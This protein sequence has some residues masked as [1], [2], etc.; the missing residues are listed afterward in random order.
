MDRG[1][2]CFLFPQTTLDEGLM[3]ISIEQSLYFA[4]M[5]QMKDNLRRIEQVQ[6]AG[7]RFVLSAP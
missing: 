1:N 5:G 6:Y 2:A 3:I 7:Y 4:N